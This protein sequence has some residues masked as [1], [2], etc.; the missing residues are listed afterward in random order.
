ELAGSSS[1]GSR[2]DVC[3]YERDHKHSQWIPVGGF[4]DGIRVVSYDSAKDT[5]VVIVSG[6][7]RELT[8][9]RATAGVPSGAFQQARPIGP[10]PAAPIASAP[11]ASGAPE[12]TTAAAQD[13][14]EARMLVSD[15][16]EIGAQQRKAYQEAK[17]RE[18][19][20]GAPSQ[21]N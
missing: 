18:A 20:A 16:L 2:I 5:A 1:Q 14:R 17:Q 21:G 8:M 10:V 19:Q 7:R 11:R 15:L 4:V 6:T 3:I 9:R 13:Q 12:T